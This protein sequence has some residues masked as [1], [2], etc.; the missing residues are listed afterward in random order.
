[1]HA[2]YT[3]SSV[4]IQ[5]GDIRAL[6]FL[7]ARVCL[8]L[9][10]EQKQNPAE[11]N[12]VQPQIKPPVLYAGRSDEDKILSIG[13]IGSTQAMSSKGPTLNALNARKSCV[14]N[15][16]SPKQSNMTA[17]LHCG[18]DSQSLQQLVYLHKYARKLSN[19]QEYL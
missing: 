4:L 1:M 10:F 9:D 11:P 14:A 15:Q 6:E 16:Q 2:W 17:A 8:S 13:S 19:N 5:D 12:I 3:G 7:E 18:G